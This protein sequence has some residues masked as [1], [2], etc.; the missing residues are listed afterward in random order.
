MNNIPI[1][2]HHDS[3]TDNPYPEK[4]ID[5]LER[6]LFEFYKTEVQNAFF[7]NQ[8]SI[9]IDF[10]KLDMFDPSMADQ[11]LDKP[12]LILKTLCDASHRLDT[13]NRRSGGLRFSISNLP[14]Y[15]QLSSLREV[16]SK[17]IGKLVS[18]EGLI[19]RRGNNMGVLD[20]AA[21]ECSG[22][23]RVYEIPQ[24]YNEGLITPVLCKDCGNTAKSGFRFLKNESTLRD[25]QYI[26]LQDPFGE[27]TRDQPRSMTIV[28]SEELIDT[29]MPGDLVRITG[30]P[31]M[32]LDK[33]KKHYK[34]YIEANHVYP[35]I[36]SFDDVHITREDEDEIIK[37]S[38]NPQLFD[39][40]SD[41]VAPGV[42]GYKEIKEA[43]TCLLFG[44]TNK[45]LDDGE[46]LRSNSHIFI[47]GD[48]GV[49]KTRLLSF[50]S[51]F[52]PN[53][54]MAS[55]TGST[56]VG[57][58]AAAVKDDDGNWNLEAGAL[59]LADGGVACIDEFDK[60]RESDFKSLLEAM[61]SQE[62]TIRKAGIMATL[63]TRTSILAA[64]NPLGDRFDDYSPMKDQVKI[65]DTILSR[66]DLIFIIQ[67]K[68]DIERDKEISKHIFKKHREKTADYPI[69]ID[70]FRKYIAY[71]RQHCHPLHTDES[72]EV[73]EN[74]YLELRGGVG[75][76]ESM[77]ITPRQEEGLIRLAEASAKA[78]LRDEVLQEDS[79][80]AIRILKYCLFQIGYDPDTGKIDINR[81]EGRTSTSEKDLLNKV[82][83]IVE[84]YMDDLGEIR[85]FRDCKEDVAEQLHLQEER[86]GEL[87]IKAKQM[88]KNR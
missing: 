50:V 47:V 33:K 37:L 17:N 46:V 6:F 62:V 8:E 12:T 80:L 65:P 44:G 75:E 51:R 82:W 84:E 79:E 43:I 66:F 2:I 81:V 22:C 58:T 61:E 26:K 64:A 31:Q 9:V 21:F 45:T 25:I 88:N 54:I 86:A 11:L 55:G 39:L 59:V 52:A 48:P 70:M 76:G 53:G 10:M 35:L 18:V 78:H 42:K 32:Q 28:F 16:N 19:K 15:N 83:S 71:A 13:H 24:D 23:M 85:G 7:E 4:N 60:M 87:I 20:T 67:D 30:I 40:L 41:S 38:Q 29:V 14:N 68:P 56:G 73:I 3:V 1:P 34:Y 72:Q 69:N 63:P 36:K 74:F 49:A 57:L 27:S 5:K 77:P